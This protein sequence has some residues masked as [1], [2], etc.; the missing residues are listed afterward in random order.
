[1]HTYQSLLPHALGHHQQDVLC[2]VAA[3]IERFLDGDQ[4]LLFD[5]VAQQPG[6]TDRSGSHEATRARGRLTHPSSSQ[7]LCAKEMMSAARPL[8]SQTTTGT[9]GSSLR[10]SS[11]MEITLGPP[12]RIRHTTGTP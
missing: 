2:L 1:M 6:A 9:G 4:Q 11:M 7:Y 10:L 8:P 5:V 12:S 3:V